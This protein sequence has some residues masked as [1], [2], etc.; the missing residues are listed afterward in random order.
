[1]N[2]L[3]GWVV[4]CGA[5]G[6]VFIAAWLVEAKKAVAGSIAPALTAVFTPLTTLM[7]VTYLATI[8]ATGDVVEVDPSVLTLTDVILVLVL[9][10]LLFAI[11]ARDPHAPPR[12]SDKLQLVLVASALL[13]D[14]LMLAAML[15]RI[16]EFGVSPNK[17]AALGLNLI[18]LANVAWHGWLSIGFLGGRPFSALPRWQTTYLPVFAAWAALVAVV[19]PPVFGWK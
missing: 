15:G 16:A 4:P 2:A 12:L 18:L 9:G 3:L 10:L 7:L 6:A 11:S 13:I 1:M 19:F 8:L 5:V 14:A 17:V